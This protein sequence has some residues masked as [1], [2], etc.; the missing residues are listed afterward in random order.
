M[1]SALVTREDETRVTKGRD[2]VPGGDVTAG[3]S[4]DSV[5]LREE[6]LAAE[7]IFKVERASL[8]RRRKCDARVLLLEVVIQLLQQRLAVEL[9]KLRGGRGNVRVIR[10]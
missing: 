10:R 3:H 6:V 2:D 7:H 4:S 1:L 8:W 9:D 5:Y